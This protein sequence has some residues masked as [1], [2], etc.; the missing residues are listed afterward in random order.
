M[1]PLIF[2]LDDT[3]IESFPTYLRLHQRIAG[4]LGWRVPSRE[5]LTVYGETWEATLAQIWPEADLTPFVAR[6]DAAGNV[7]TSLAVV[8]VKNTGANKN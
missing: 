3:L 6:Y 2:D 5:E 1:S 7:G 4:E 8:K